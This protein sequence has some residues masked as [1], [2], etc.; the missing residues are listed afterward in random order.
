MNEGY[1]G[2]R[3]VKDGTEVLGLSNCVNSL[4][5]MGG[6]LK[7]SVR[8]REWKSFF[9]FSQISKC[10]WLGG[11]GIQ[12]RWKAGIPYLSYTQN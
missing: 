9:G 5:E 12:E 11:N 4:T 7:V 6:K 8:C 2:K 1:E 3:I 10:R